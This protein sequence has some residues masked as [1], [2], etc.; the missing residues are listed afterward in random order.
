[1][2][3]VLHAHNRRLQQVKARDEAVRAI[4]SLPMRP[5][6]VNAGGYLDYFLADIAVRKA[7]PPGEVSFTNDAAVY[8][9]R[10]FR[11]CPAIG[12]SIAPTAMNIIRFDGS[13]REI[14]PLDA[15]LVNTVAR[16]PDQPA[17]D[18]V[19]G[20]TVFYVPFVRAT[21]SQ[22]FLVRYNRHV[23][24]PVFDRVERTTF[25]RP[26]EQWIEFRRIAGSELAAGVVPVELLMV[27]PGG[28]TEF[29]WPVRQGIFQ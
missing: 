28:P 23:G 17:L 24:L 12:F 21:A 27:N 22:P 11:N 25:L 26:W 10:G 29:D 4:A 19:L 18:E 2:G 15:A 8:Q 20:E 13:D 3:P 16:F 1:M 6:A 7:L 5:V 14:T 9:V